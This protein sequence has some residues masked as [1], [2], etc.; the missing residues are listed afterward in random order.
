MKAV[1]L[2]VAARNGAGL[3][4]GNVWT[5]DTSGG[6]W[7]VAA[8]WE[9]PDF[10][11]NGQG[12]SAYFNPA[13]AAGVGVTLDA[14]VT[15]GG[16]TFN[17]NSPTYGYTLSGSAL[18]MESTG[19]YS[20]PTVVNASG[21][22]T[23]ASQ[24]VL[25]DG[26]DLCTDEGNELRVTGGVTG[27]GALN[28]NTHRTTGAGQVNLSVAPT[29]TGSVKT[30]S[31]RVVM[32]DFSF[33]QTASQL[34]LGPGTLLYTGPDVEIPG[35]TLS[36]GS[37]RC[38]VFDH[39]SD[40]TLNAL[41]VSGT[42]AFLKRGAGTLRLH[43]TGTFSP[44]TKVNHNNDTFKTLGIVKPNGDCPTVTMRG[45]TIAKGTIIQ[46]EVDDPA[47]AP[48][49]DLAANEM[50][51]GSWTL[52]G[53]ATYILNNGTLTGTASIYV[54]YY[55]N[56][57]LNPIPTLTYV[58]NGGSMTAVNLNCGYTNNRWAN[59]TDIYVEINGGTVEL[60]SN[61]NM[62]RDKAS[63]TTQTCRFVMNGGSFEIGANLHLAYKANAPKG[64]ADLNGGV[65]TVKGS[66]YPA[67]GGTAEST[68]RLNEGAVL[69]CNG[70]VA[71][72]DGATTRF[73]GNGGTFRPLCLTTAGQTMAANAF[74][75]LYASTNG[76][77]VDTSETLDG[78][79][80]TI[81][82][83]IA[84]DPDCEGADGGLVKRGAGT[85]TLS[86]AN[87]YTGPTVV[88]G[89]ILALSGTGTLGTGSGLSVA[90]GAICDLGGTA[91]AVADVTASGLVRN[92]T[93]TVTDGLLV[94]EDV[95]SVDGDLTLGNA[96][97][98]D[99]A[100]RQG[101]DLD[102]GEPVAFVTGETTLPG[103]ARATNAGEVR[104]VVFARDGNTVY[105]V[106]APTGTTIIFR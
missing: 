54:G 89:G 92:G 105:A 6:A 51:I 13:K 66:I 106:A 73:Y 60:S 39:D 26:T 85:L 53:D 46:G 56:N 97:T 68:L 61:L 58:Q 80:Y 75:Y 35:L 91:Q 94:G 37:S 64:F 21:T 10:I 93:L 83:P 49:V 42:S 4:N 78:A 76:L 62:G 71:P 23:I 18:T 2:T 65:V 82:M 98:V 27:A 28:V 90:N 59:K 9:N 11:P 100:G 17:A 101:L 44:N 81:A 95:L 70:V 103:G 88:E 40:V 36:S 5:S 24:V 43:G 7:S 38:A 67:Y 87:T 41:T 20:T 34:K 8:N 52:Q 31:G 3:S 16:L 104:G 12:Q 99:F 1:V 57:S 32:N 72:A 30:G 63:K 45:V 74:S 84:T 19:M 86:G 69:R 14:P 77:V 55:A 96:L 15:L 50:T 79:A 25:S 22:N 48:T 102:A 47:N 33:I 29:F